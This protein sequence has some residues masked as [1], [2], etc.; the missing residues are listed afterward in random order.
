MKWKWIRWVLFALKRIEIWREK[1]SKEKQLNRTMSKAR[2]VAVCLKVSSKLP[3]IWCD[4]ELNRVR[5]TLVN[6]LSIK[7]PMRIKLT[8]AKLRKHKVKNFDFT[9]DDLFNID[10]L[11]ETLEKIFSFRLK[12]IGGGRNEKFVNDSLECSLNQQTTIKTNRSIEKFTCT[13]RLASSSY[14]QMITGQL[15]DER[16]DSIAIENDSLTS[17]FLFTLL[18]TH[19]HFIERVWR[20]SRPLFDSNYRQRTGLAS[21]NIESLKNLKFDRKIIKHRF[22]FQF[23]INKQRDL[24]SVRLVIIGHCLLTGQ[25]RYEQSETDVHQRRDWSVVVVFSCRSIIQSILLDMLINEEIRFRNVTLLS[26]SSSS[27]RSICVTVRL[28]LSFFFLSSSSFTT[29]RKQ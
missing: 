8:E 21:N 25:I 19:T 14:L 2:I 24:K 13:R 5:L 17:H 1:L 12:S 10:S 26:S 4:S 18:H 11:D 15:Q 7:I 20:H 29:E 3:R 6:R 9:F 28:L 16:F 22:R 23:L 27:F